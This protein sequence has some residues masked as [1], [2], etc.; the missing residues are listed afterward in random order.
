MEKKLKTGLKEKSDWQWKKKANLL[1]VHIITY[2]PLLIKSNS[3][4]V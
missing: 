3:Q 2:K 1:W 4:T